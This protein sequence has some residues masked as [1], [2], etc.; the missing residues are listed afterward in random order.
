MLK[1][2]E[3]Y[4]KL[5]QEIRDRMSSPAV[6]F[7]IKKL[8]AKYNISL[9][10]IIMRIM[11]GEIELDKSVE[12]F[13]RE[14]KMNLSQSQ[15]LA[16]ELKDT[17]EKKEVKEMRSIT[18][19]VI[20]PSTQE[21]LDAFSKEDEQEI[22]QISKDMGKSHTDRNGQI[23]DRVNKIFEQL[24]ISFSS[25]FLLDRFKKVLKINLLGV[26]DSD[27][28]LEILLKPFDKGGVGLSSNEAKRAI[29]IL[30]K[31][32]MI[33]NSSVKPQELIKNKINKIQPVEI[34]R[35]VEYDLEKSIKNRQQNKEANIE[36]Q[37]P[38]QTIQK[39]EKDLGEKIKEKIK[40][41]TMGPIDEL[42]YLNLVDFRRLHEDPMK[43]IIKVIEK[44]NLLGDY[45][46]NK[47]VEGIKAWRESPVN[48]MYLNIGRMSMANNKSIKDT[49]Y[50]LGVEE[51]LRQ[52]ELDAIG[53]LNY[54][55]RTN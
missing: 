17:I 7:A 38:V 33:H 18:P 13:I 48:K 52:D 28:T 20:A 16:K 46:Y 54:K 8:E 11:V 25:Q 22:K 2:L 40:P 51:S 55:L 41:R 39:A 50:E 37:K 31:E 49:I 23:D 45:K 1:I 14:L 15:V 29:H 34:A 10:I 47:R 12:F 44:I 19:P 35:D 36:N 5:P 6:L 32:K 9:H 21:N 3:K 42:K 27:A 30:G 4:N 43:A 24:K 53:D 26:R